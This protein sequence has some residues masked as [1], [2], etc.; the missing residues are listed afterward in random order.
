M[1]THE[2]AS[3]TAKREV[4]PYLTG[5]MRVVLVL[6]MVIIRRT[7]EETQA[8]TP[9][10]TERRESLPKCGPRQKEVSCW[11]VAPQD[12]KMAVWCSGEC[13]WSEGPQ[14]TET[15]GPIRGG[16]VSG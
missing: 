7:A 8:L 1:V 2:C 3:L 16:L 15:I 9:V 13:C 14:R 5:G 12:V 11:M 4:Q 10:H 6:S